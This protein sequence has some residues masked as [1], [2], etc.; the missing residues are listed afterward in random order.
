MLKMTHRGIVMIDYPIV[1]TT[2]LDSKRP[3]AALLGYPCPAGLP[4]PCCWPAL[5]S[6]L[7]VSEEENFLHV[8]GPVPAQAFPE[9]RL[10]NAGTEP[11]HEDLVE[12]VNLLYCNLPC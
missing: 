2:F 3:T 7:A 10:G 11:A 5:A 8:V 6:L 4:L 12:C 1:T 9:L